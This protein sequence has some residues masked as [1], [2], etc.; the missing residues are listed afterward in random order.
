MNRF[1]NWGNRL[2]SG[3]KSYNII[4]ARKRWIGIGAVLIVIS[5]LLLIFPSI[6]PSIEFR[7]GTEFRVNDVHGASQTVG[8]E[9]LAKLP[10]AKEATVTSI[11]SDS[12]RVQ[13]G[14]MS[15]K[16][17]RE[18]VSTLAKAYGTAEQHIDATQIGPSWGHDVTVKA[19]KSLIIFFILVGLMLVAYFKT[20][21]M[22]AAALF[23]LVH[24]VL[25]TAAAFALTRVEVSPATVIGVLTILAY[26]LYDTVVV[27]D[28]VRELTDKFEDQARFTYGERVN[29]AVNQT[30]VRS[31]NTSVVALLPMVSILVIST[32]ILGGGTLR[33]ISMALTIGTIVGTFSSIF[34]ASPAL[35][36]LRG[37]QKKVKEHTKLV[38]RRRQGI[39]AKD[40]R[41]GKKTI[42]M[43]EGAAENATMAATSPGHHLGRAAQ[44]SRKPRSKR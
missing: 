8:R 37:R 36:Y 21:T 39:S 23:A 38:Y 15:T 17:S 3:E 1:S 26:S 43:D 28:K 14:T 7:G 25:L 32:V 44:P 34:I 12:I 40:L 31:I 13:T 10:Q 4:G 18:V 33:D 30:M 41:R 24:D 19:I 9:A 22:A 11:G 42:K 27:F 5:T 29:L 16:E 20:W 2:Y 6:L 35:V